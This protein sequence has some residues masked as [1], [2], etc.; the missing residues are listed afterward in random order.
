M[1]FLDSDVNNSN[2]EPMDLLLV[3]LSLQLSLITQKLDFGKAIAG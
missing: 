1:L 3:P 2:S